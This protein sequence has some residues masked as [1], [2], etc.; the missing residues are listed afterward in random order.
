MLSFLMPS[1]RKPLA[2]IRDRD[3]RRQNV[4]MMSSF[5]CASAAQGEKAKANIAVYILI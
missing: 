1:S 3:K 4:L 5:V 2:A